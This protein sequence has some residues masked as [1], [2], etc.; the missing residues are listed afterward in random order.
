MAGRRREGGWGPPKP[1][2]LFVA[3]PLPSWLDPIFGSAVFPSPCVLE[4]REKKKRKKGKKKKNIRKKK[5]KQ[6]K[7]TEKKKGKTVPVTGP[8][9]K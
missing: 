3:S 6:K 9:L 4:K 8:I 2:P 1:P 5:K 7:K